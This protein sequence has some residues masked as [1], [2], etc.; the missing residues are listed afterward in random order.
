MIKRLNLWIPLA[1]SVLFLGMLTW[2][3]LNR[4]TYPYDLEWMEGGMLMHAV[5][6]SLGKGVY[7]PPTAEFVPYFYTPGYPYLLS[8]LASAEDISYALGRGVSVFAS[9]GTMALLFWCVRRESNWYYGVIGAGLYAALFRTNGA[10]YDIARPDSLFIFLILAA[11]V[12]TRCRDDLKS[13]CIVG[14][15]CALA[16]LTKQTASVFFAAIVIVQ[17][18]K[19]WRQGLSCFCLGL[20]GCLVV[21][22]AI[23]QST[24]GWFWTYIFEG[25]QGHVFIWSNFLFDYWRDLL[26]LAPI[27]LWGPWLQFFQKK[28]T[29]WLSVILVFHWIYAF[30]RRVTTLD[31]S[32]HMYYRELWYENPRTLILIPPLAMFILSIVIAVRLRRKDFETSPIWMWFF[33]AGCGVSALNHSTQ[34]AYANCFMPISVAACILIPLTLRDVLAQRDVIAASAISILLA[35]QF[36]ALLYSPSTQIPTQDDLTAHTEVLKRI[37][38]ETGTLMSPSNP[39]LAYKATGSLHTHQ[40]GIKDVGYLGGLADLPKVIAQ[41]KYRTILTAHHQPLPNLDKYYYQSSPLDFP[42]NNALRMKTGYLTRVNT[43]WFSRN[44]GERT[45]GR[46]RSATFENDENLTAWRFEGDAFGREHSR[47]R[48]RG[49]NVQGG[50]VFRSQRTGKGQMQADAKGSRSQVSVLAGGR[51]KA[52]RISVR[53]ERGTLLD[54]AIQTKDGHRLRRYRWRFS[55]ISNGALTITIIDGDSDGYLIVD[56]IRFR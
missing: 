14:F 24:G 55:R 23:N 7:L 26:F 53:D 19:G 49:R 4:L 22:W 48:F 35:I 5:R 47:Q 51:C 20:F 37:S 34:W 10:F 45:S 43:L 56:D 21:I 33:V 27:L 16:F 50:F 17:F 41:Q 31:Y 11:M 25:H 40:M 18:V 36:S 13:A 6:L 46:G 1:F 44:D 12:L 2:V 9:C 28:T 3:Y 29:V 32:P 52:C 15:L 54:T 8:L 42:T 39:F 30:W 38:E